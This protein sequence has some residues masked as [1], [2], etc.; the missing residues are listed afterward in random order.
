M[1]QPRPFRKFKVTIQCTHANV[2]QIDLYHVLGSA[3][4]PKYTHLLSVLNFGYVF[5]RNIYL[6]ISHIA[7]QLAIPI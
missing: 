1:Q 4:Y 3:C 5:I 6:I 7:D 2:D